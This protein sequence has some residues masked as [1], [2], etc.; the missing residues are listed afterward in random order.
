[1]N[2]RGASLATA[3]AILLC[4]SGC[5]K[6]P[7]ARPDSLEALAAGYRT[8]YATTWERGV[9]AA[10]GVQSASTEALSVV[11]DPLDPKRRAV[12]ASI[13]RDDDFS[14]VA[15]GSPRAELVFSNLVRFEA[16]HDYLVQWTTF[17]PTTFEFDSDSTQLI[18]QIHQ[19]PSSGS[20]PIMLTLHDTDYA[21][22]E[23]GGEHTEH[24]RGLRICCAANDRGRWVH[25]ALRY[26]PD[27][28]GRLART[29]L[30]KDAR[31]V[32]ASTG[33][34]NAYPNDSH[35]YLKLGL[36]RPG[37]QDS[38]SKVRAMTLFYGPLSIGE[39]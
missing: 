16:G 10:V 35:A 21:F 34:P 38:A 25:W 7:P 32:Y 28:T 26:A 23:R 20:P 1:M 24:G 33:A 14:R 12:R 9:N 29:Q 2:V 19:G 8:L 17:I 6:P 3:A 31:L 15:N 27:P 22:S 18:T 4:A 30:W 11:G 13:S 5:G 39:R 37:W 36:Y